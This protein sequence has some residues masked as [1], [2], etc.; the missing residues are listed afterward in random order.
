MPRPQTLRDYQV[1]SIEKLRIHMRA[2]IQRLLLVAPTGSGKTTCAAEII[3]RAI[4]KK[5]RGRDGS[6]RPQR[7]CFM[8]HREELVTQA[9]RRL[10]GFGVEHGIIKAG[11]EDRYTPW[12]PVQVASIQTLVRRLAHVDTMSPAEREWFDFE[13]VIIDEA[14]RA[15]AATYGRILD[16]YP[17]ATVLGLSVGPESVIE[18][19]GGLFG[20]GFVGTIEEAWDRVTALD[21]FTADGYD[22]RPM[23]GVFCRGYEPRT[24]FCWKP[25]RH[26]IRHACTQPYRRL[27]AAGPLGMT[28]DHS[29]YV[30][31]ERGLGCPRADAIAPGAIVAY[32][33]GRAW[34]SERNEDP[35]DVC[36]M[37][38]RHYASPDKVKVCVDLT[39]IDRQRLGVTPGEWYT[40][41]RGSNGHYL[42]LP[43]YMRHRFSLPAP[44]WIYTEGANSTGIRPRIDLCRWAYVLGFFLGDGWLD[45]GRVNFATGLHET[46]DLLQRLAVLDGVTWRPT[47]RKTPARSEEIRCANTLVATLLRSLFGRVRA[48][49]KRIPGGWIISWPE[50][51][52]RELL[53][54]LIDSDGHL[55]RKDRGRSRYYFATTSE[56]LAQS[57]A[58][59]VRSLGGMPSIALRKADRGGIVAGRRIISRRPAYS[60]HFSTHDVMGTGYSEKCGARSKHHRNAGEARVR[61]SAPADAPAFVYD[62]EVTGHPSFVASGVLVHNTAT[63]WRSDG[64]GLGEL[65]HELVVAAEPRDLI[66]Q[67]YLVAYDGFA[68]YEKEGVDLSGVRTTAGDFN[69]DDLATKQREKKIMG[70]V[71]DEWLAHARD[72]LTIL[73]ACNV[74]H[75]KEMAEAFRARGIPA[76]HVDGETPDDEREAILGP[77]GRF[78]RGQTRVVCNVGILGEGYDQPR[79]SCV[80]LTCATM[81]VAKAMQQIG[82]VMRPVPCACGLN[83]DW[84]LAACPACGRPPVKT[85]AWIHDH[86]GILTMH[87]APDAE[88]DWSLTADEKKRAKR[89]REDG[90]LPPLRQCLTDRNGP[91]CYRIFPS[92][93]SGCPGC[94]KAVAVTSTKIREVDGEKV[95]VADV[96]AVPQQ[97]Q[98]AAFDSFLGIARANG[99]RHGWVA[100]SFKSR[101]RIWPPYK[102]TLE[103]KRRFERDPQWIANFNRR[104]AGQRQ[105]G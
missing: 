87:G 77:D 99:Y 64:K 100:Q 85:K 103:A 82:R 58:S 18:L 37:L 54:G 30:I 24:G 11:H 13:L 55:A 16:H 3:F 75:S 53:Q 47:V 74:Q 2:G 1:S 95:R 34:G 52:R 93:I 42:P 72:Q 78:A 102:W 31:D 20:A 79:A 46:E 5:V 48:W 91:G 101:F 26:I 60:V 50:H 33:D 28:D 29:V 43:L 61:S 96:C 56:R 4:A 86:A 68:F 84:H 89:T 22:I 105:V 25:M 9:A 80:V 88:R 21:L 7:V 27:W 38:A 35:V 97:E 57:V 76:E 12:L 70:R 83:F 71:I 63:P 19:K 104:L 69:S 62:I 41:R 90:G 65:F 49:E 94:G 23:H 40:V 81:S 92:S 36:D 66:A 32:D 8:C 98:R 44:T 73:F 6:M 59:L 51:A 67:G 17:Q 15:R 14:H 39:D 45:G 10:D